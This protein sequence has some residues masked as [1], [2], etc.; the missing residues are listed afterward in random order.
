MPVS[1]SRVGPQMRS[2]SFERFAGACAILT[3][4]V[5]FVYAVAFVLLHE[6]LLSALFLMLCRKR[7]GYRVSGKLPLGICC[8]ENDR[9]CG[10]R[11][12]LL[13][14]QRFGSELPWLRVD[15]MCVWRRSRTEG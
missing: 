8:E 5:A 9:S 13:N 11:T 2:A 12:P 10:T 6:E 1:R 4:I 15:E 3:A 7:R 14:L